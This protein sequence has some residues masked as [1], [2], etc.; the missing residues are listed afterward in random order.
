MAYIYQ[1]TNN[2]NG[3]KYIGLTYLDDPIERWKKHL[4]EIK[5]HQD[6]RPLYDAMKKHGIENFTF[7][8]LEETDFPEEREQ[9]YI[10]LFQTFGKGYNA[11]LGGDGHK[12]AFSTEESIQQLVALHQSGKSCQEIAA[13][14][15]KDAMTI[16][17]KLKGLGFD[18]NFKNQG[19]AV[20]Q[21]SKT[22][23]LIA[24]YDNAS[25]ASQA[26]GKDS[27]GRGHITAVCRGTRKSAYG[28]VWEYAGVVQR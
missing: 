18:L 24:T 25:L 16:S 14:L 8:V 11:T 7:Q 22:G 12:T 6:K 1:I 17:R 20:N 21:F 15:N 19:V 5:S 4:R 13:T 23:E 28:F 10:Q 2:I 27:A 9:Y 3:K 26:I